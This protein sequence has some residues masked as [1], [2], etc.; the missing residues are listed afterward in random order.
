[1]KQIQISDVLTL[2]QPDSQWIITGNEY[3][4]IQWLNEITVTKE[5]LLT[6][7]EV[8]KKHIEKIEN[9]KTVAK[10]SAQ[11]KLAAL[12]LTPDEVTAIIGA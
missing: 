4:G 9:D 7:I 11:A 3:E 2:I 5:E 8:Y 1:M 6:G 12:G 10:T